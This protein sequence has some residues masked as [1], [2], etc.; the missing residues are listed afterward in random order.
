M[1][2]LRVSPTEIV[3]LRGLFEESFLIECS[4]VRECDEII[5]AL[6]SGK[7][8]PRLGFLL[9]V[10]VTREAEVIGEG[11][12]AKTLREALVE[13]GVKLGGGLRVYASDSWRPSYFKRI[14]EEAKRFGFRYM[15]VFLALDLGVIGPLY[16]PG[17]PGYLC[18]EQQL[19]ASTGWLFRAV[20]DY[21]DREALPSNP[22]YLKFLAYL[23]A[24]IIRRS[25]D[26]L[27]GRAVLVDFQSFYIDVAKIYLTPLCAPEEVSSGL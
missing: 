3:V 1:R 25:V 18:L 13:S 14:E 22:L 24:L 19:T 21:A 17:S 20:R 2:A 23:T 9:K 12:L 15:P 4:N 16:E 6:R 26:E 8:H 7:S 11:I 5:E 27:R 10:E